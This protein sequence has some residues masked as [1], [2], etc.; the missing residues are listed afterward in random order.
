LSIDFGEIPL[1][2]PKFG[3]LSRTQQHEL[4][5]AFVDGCSI[6]ISRDGQSWDDCSTP[7][8]SLDASYRIKSA[9][10]PIPWDKIIPAYQYAAMNKSGAVM[11]F[12]TEPHREVA[13]SYWYAGSGVYETTYPFF[14]DTTGVNWMNSVTKRPE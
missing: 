4:F 12:E 13:R 7:T 3:D 8:W 10:L 11:L 1:R 5:D 9:T 6:E 2:H 14:I